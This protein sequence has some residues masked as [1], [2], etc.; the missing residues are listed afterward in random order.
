MNKIDSLKL[1]RDTILDQIRYMDNLLRDKSNPEEHR[2]LLVTV[3]ELRKQLST[4]QHDI[5]DLLVKRV[6]QI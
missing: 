2:K 1:Q 6:Q 5:I 4:I 3:I